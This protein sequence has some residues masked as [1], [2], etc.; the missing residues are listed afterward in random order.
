MPE[1]YLKEDA[2]FISPILLFLKLSSD[3]F[4]YVENKP[5]N[6]KSLIGKV[7]PLPLL[8][9]C[10][11]L[12]V[13]MYYMSNLI[14][15]FTFNSP[16][17]ISKYC[18]VIETSS[19]YVSEQSKREI[20]RIK[21]PLMPYAKQAFERHKRIT[22][23]FSRNYGDNRGFLK[24]NIRKFGNLIRLNRKVSNYYFFSL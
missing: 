8:T 15:G 21:I 20:F 5:K 6:R 24:F 10:Y 16:E 2:H 11:S 14:S 13:R 23:L 17:R 19:K 3:E 22:I 18:R 9:F 12:P 1:K 7:K 4:E